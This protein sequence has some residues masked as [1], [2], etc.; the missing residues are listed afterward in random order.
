MSVGRDRICNAYQIH[1]HADCRN[2]AEEVHRKCMPA[3]VQN[4]VWVAK[5]CHHG[6]GYGQWSVDNGLRLD[7]II[8]VAMSYNFY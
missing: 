6:H 8:N 2:K 1:T 4:A 5:K 7:W 3:E